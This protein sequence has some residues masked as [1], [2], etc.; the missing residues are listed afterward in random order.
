MLLLY[1][2]NSTSN[3]IRSVWFFAMV[4]S[5]H[6]TSNSASSIILGRFRSVLFVNC[7]YAASKFWYNDGSRDW[8]IC[9]TQSWNASGAIEGQCIMIWISLSIPVRPL[10]FCF[11]FSNSIST[12]ANIFQEERKELTWVI[13]TVAFEVE[14]VSIVYWKHDLPPLRLC[15]ATTM[16]CLLDTINVHD[17]QL[18]VYGIRVSIVLK[19]CFWFLWSGANVF[20]Y[21]LFG[22]QSKTP[23][24]VLVVNS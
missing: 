13:G 15:R 1:V 9:W 10:V 17:I 14:W 7:S 21:C 16:L 20:I 5:A 6:F 3:L 2:F 22:Q 19:E 8:W 4:S 12:W 23:V 11:C 18:V 24:F